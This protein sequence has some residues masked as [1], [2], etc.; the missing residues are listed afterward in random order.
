MLSRYK[1]FLGVSWPYALT[2]D[3]RAVEPFA[4]LPAEPLA[5]RLLFTKMV[6]SLEKS[7]SDSIRLLLCIR[8]KSE[9]AEAIQ[10]IN[11]AFYSE[12]GYIY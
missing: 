7:D 3:F 6:S 1:L 8:P 10:K 2:F 11:S 4:T 5:G 9:T 12:A